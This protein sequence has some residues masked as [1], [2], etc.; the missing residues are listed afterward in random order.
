M[1]NYWK[2]RAASNAML[3]ARICGHR[4][5]VNKAE[6]L[7]WSGD[8]APDARWAILCA[9]EKLPERSLQ[10][11]VARFGDELSLEEYGQRIGRTRE[12]VRQLEARALRQMR[13]KLRRD[14]MQTL[15]DSLKVTPVPGGPFDPEWIGTKMAA[16]LTELS[17]DHIRYLCRTNRV[18]HKEHPFNK[19]LILISRSSLEAYVQGTAQH[20]RRKGIWK[21]DGDETTGF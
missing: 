10:V 15:R 21:G 20:G 17:R 1:K 4:G 7:I 6:E 13:V 11:L 19:T 9:L 12:R 8:K 18:M 14:E 3:A 16:H 2:L 5:P